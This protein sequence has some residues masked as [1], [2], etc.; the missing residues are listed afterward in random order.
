MAAIPH[1]QI[2]SEFKALNGV[3]GPWLRL[4]S[5]G[6]GQVEAGLG[7][8]VHDLLNLLVGEHVFNHNICITLDTLNRRHK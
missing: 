1:V 6:L 8:H 7:P 3:A 2:R 4:G 5:E